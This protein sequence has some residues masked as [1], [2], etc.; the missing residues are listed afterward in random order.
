MEKTFLI[1]YMSN[2]GFEAINKTIDNY[3]I[4]TLNNN[5]N[6]RFLIYDHDKL[7]LNS[8][9]LMKLILINGKINDDDIKQNIMYHILTNNDTFHDSKNTV[10]QDS[11]NLSETD[12]VAR[13]SKKVAEISLMMYEDRIF[14]TFDP[15]N[16]FILGNS[17]QQKDIR[18]IIMKTTTYDDILI[19]FNN[20]NPNT[21][22]VNKVSKSISIKNSKNLSKSISKKLSRKSTNQENTI[23]DYSNMI[24]PYGLEKVVFTG[25]GMKGLVYIGAFVGL[26]ATGEIFY[27][28][29]YAG[30]SAG[31]LTALISG[32]MT[33]TID[34]YDMLKTLSLRS[35]ITKTNGICERYQKAIRYAFERFSKRNLDTFYVMPNYTW[36][37]IIS[38]I[39]TV[40]KQQGLYD[41]QKSGFMIWYAIIC[42]RLCYI[43]KNNLDNMILIRKPDGSF[44]DY[45]DL[46][47]ININDDNNYIDTN[48]DMENE[49]FEGWV[50][51]RFFTFKEYHQLTGKTIVLTGTTTKPLDTVY[52]THTNQNY[53]DHNVMVCAMASMSIPFVFKAPKIN[54]SYNLDGGIFDNYPLTHCDKKNKDKVTHYNNKI[55]GYMIDDKNTII[56]GYEILRE[57]WIVYNSFIDTSNITKICEAT[58]Y[59]EL[60]EMFFDIRSEIYK[61]LYFTDNEIDTFINTDR[62]HMIVDDFNIVQL[63]NILKSS[64]IND[65]GFKLPVL[66]I[67]YIKDTLQTLDSQY[68]HMD[69]LF[70]IGKKTDLSDVIELSMKHGEAFINLFSVI[71]HDL[72]LLNTIDMNN[73]N[74]IKY[75]KMLRLI[76]KNILVY[77]ELKGNFMSSESFFKSSSVYFVDLMKTLYKKITDFDKDLKIA[78][79]ELNKALIKKKA[80][81]KKKSDILINNLD[82]SIQILMTIISKIVTGGT[83][84]NI[85]TSDNHESDTD[86]ITNTSTYSR[87]L[88]YI[89]NT[90]IAGIVYKYLCIVNDRI[91]NDTFNQM[92]TIQLNTFEANT[93]HFNMDD[94]LKTR[95]I[96]EGYTKTIQYFTSILRVMEMTN[97]TRSNDEFIESNDLKFKKIM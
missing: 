4:I 97:K 39:N 43:M 63:E 75:Q 70:K 82:S 27:L 40:I 44:V 42:K 81:I 52:Y 10:S 30:T 58:N 71:I 28:N 51:E 73:E 36:Y 87:A 8:Q 54:G 2:I 56:S 91:C 80:D 65:K 55:F 67:D 33:P 93:L 45:N 26:L 1:N 74:V 37:G 77:Y 62:D 15:Y 69:V 35:I 13:Y 6:E 19:D 3:K 90:E 83:G 18:D 25:G 85:D 41:A 64:N 66:G 53:R 9:S 14:F 17:N 38:I 23:N 16:N 88:D 78:Y 21:H 57:L 60:S 59:V 11:V 48:I 46:N 49:M 31:A 76:V 32:C 68:R 20:S 22:S 92:R 5:A 7:V 89:F 72:D 86:V 12:I 94:E 95:L 24:N 61:L 96:Y 50:L 29:H 79:D 34:E 84:Y 47:N